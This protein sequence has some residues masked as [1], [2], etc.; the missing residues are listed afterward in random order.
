VQRRGDA[1]D[2][3]RGDHALS[4]RAARRAVALRVELERFP[5]LSF[6]AQL[7]TSELVSNT[8]R[9][10]TVQNGDAF[11]LTIG[12][13]ASTLHIELTD[14]GPGVDPLFH[15]ARY[16]R[17]GSCRHG[18]YLV[19]ALADRWGY[20]RHEGSKMWFEIDLVPGRTPWR[21]R[22]PAPETRASRSSR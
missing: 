10:A 5:E 21:G 6:I 2:V 16:R 18:I 22:Q 12:C 19:N 4:L 7:L 20:R 9:H 3:P 8:V 1:N 14:H 13:D 15:L 17:A 11:V